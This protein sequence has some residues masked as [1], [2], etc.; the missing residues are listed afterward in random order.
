MSDSILNGAPTRSART[1]TRIFIT[2]TIAARGEVGIEDSRALTPKAAPGFIPKEALRGTIPRELPLRATILRELPLP[3]IVLKEV[4]VPFR[5]IVLKGVLF[6][7][8]IPREA[9]LPGIVPREVALRDIILRE[10]HLLNISLPLPAVL[11]LRHPLLMR[12]IISRNSPAA[13]R[14]QIAPPGAIWA[15]FES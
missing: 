3:A 1:M 8:I 14:S 4:P 15:F 6:R 7:G 11:N 5:G 2:A 13:A 9:P 12:N 10:A